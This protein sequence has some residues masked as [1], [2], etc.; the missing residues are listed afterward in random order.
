MR[1]QYIA[2]AFGCL[3]LS[4]CLKEEWG[5]IP[6]NQ[7][8]EEKKEWDK[9]KTVDFYFI[10][11][12]KDKPIEN[13]GEVSNYINS[14]GKKISIAVVDRSDVINY[15][16]VYNAQVGTTIL[17]VNT[18]RFSSFAFQKYAGMNIEGSTI[19]FNHKINEE[20]SIHI[21][22]ECNLK[23]LPIMTRTNVEKP[24]D[25]LVPF[26]T[27]RFNTSKQIR[28]AAPILNSFAS[29]EKNIIIGTVK[30]NI[31][32]ELNGLAK[33]IVGYNLSIACKNT[34]YAIFVLAPASWV[35][36]E[37]VPESIGK[38]TAYKISIEASVE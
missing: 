34:D 35:L 21:S 23:Y 30:S 25:I 31:V 15:P 10:S 26:S 5:V 27:I 6:N 18:N 3:L 8:I 4:S 13:Y 38:L 7:S 33:D 36:R 2:I 28:T 24:L 9:N 12:L 17:A 32:D 16:Q 19:L 20:K 11:E 1:I 37:T 22:S 29:K 14:N